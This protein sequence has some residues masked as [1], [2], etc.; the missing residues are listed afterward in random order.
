V[1]DLELPITGSLED[2]KFRIG[3]IV[4][5][6]VKN[7]LVKVA[8]SP[9][10]FIGSLF[11]GG[12][13]DIQ[14]ITFTP[15]QATL[16]E[17]DQK[18]LD[19]LRKALADR[20]GLAVDIPMVVNPAQ[21]TPVLTEAR[22]NAL[23]NG[24]ARES[25][26]EKARQ[27]DFLTTL[28]DPKDQRKLL[29]AAYRTQFGKVPQP[30]KPDRNDPAQKARDPD[31]FAAEWLEQQLRPAMQID[32]DALTDL[33]KARAAAIEEALL[34]DGDVDPS[35]VFIVVEKRGRGSATDD[36]APIRAQLSLK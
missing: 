23:L 20:P 2:P 33:G 34:K 28:S 8:T 26:G 1:S 11:G 4:W 18:K 13:E 15:G 6:M 32:E 31:D 12:G 36:T 19:A 27:P 22:W 30:P 7:L 21:D 24:A 3:P 17:E 29:T 16:G 35:R 9:F 14:F 25:F 10:T 5:K